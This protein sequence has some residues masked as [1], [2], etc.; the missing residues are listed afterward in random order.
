MKDGIFIKR[1]RENGK[2]EKASD[3]RKPTVKAAVIAGIVVV[4][5]AAGFLA[6]G[7]FVG[8]MDTIYPN[9]SVGGVKLAGLTEEE[10]Q[11]ALIDAGY[12]DS[13][14]NV[15]VTVNFPNG[16]QMTISGEE[17]GVRLLAQNAAELAWNYGRDGSFFQK[18][19]IYIKSLFSKTDL[20]QSGG[21]EWTR[22]MWRASSSVRHAFND[23]SMKDAYTIHADSIEIVKGSGGMLADPD[24]L[25]ELVVTA[26]SQSAAENSPVT[27][28]YTMTNN[29][30]EL[31]LQNIY[32]QIFV[33]P[34]SAVYDET[35]YGATKS[36]TGVSFDLDAPQEGV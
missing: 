7:F 17:S 23:K 36:V 15:A 3:K 5:L 16:D 12:E 10:A 6:T 27:V 34:V 24:E 28:D 4:V 2:H 33:E 20:G 14:N 26:F 30:D 25:Y 19:F 1:K 29:G 13:T 31:D 21:A 22:T 32:D 18:E 35:T 8:G 11:Q 9:V